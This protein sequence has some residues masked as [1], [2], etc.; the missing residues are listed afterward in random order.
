[1]TQIGH[2]GGP[3]ID[4]DRGATAELLYRDVRYRLRI[5]RYV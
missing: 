1:M 3:L 4:D 2:N 5:R